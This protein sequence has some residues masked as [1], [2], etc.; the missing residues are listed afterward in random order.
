[1][2]ILVKEMMNHAW[3]GYKKKA[4]SENEVRPISGKGHSAGI[5]G[6]GKTG[7][8]IVDALDTLYIM[9]MMN[10]FNEAKEWVEKNFFF[11][12]KTD[13][14]LF[15]TVIRF[16]AGFLA[17]GTLS[18]E[19]DRLYSQVQGFSIIQLKYSNKIEMFC[20]ILISSLSLKIGF[21]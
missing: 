10:E 5:F 15:E 4:W 17:A 14:S 2:L 11:N 21:L 3:Q 1:M 8:T 13:V 6:N 16:V 18:G 19:Q 9:G 12:S 7:A 20:S